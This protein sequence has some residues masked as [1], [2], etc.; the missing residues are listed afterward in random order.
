MNRRFVARF[1]L[2]YLQHY[3]N[4]GSSIALNCALGVLRRP[5][6]VWSSDK[7]M[8]CTQGAQK[9]NIVDGFCGAVVTV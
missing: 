7:L 4:V 3:I 6:L 5:S 1:F 9:D 2:G 8:L